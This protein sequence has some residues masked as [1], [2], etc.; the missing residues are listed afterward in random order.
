MED[1]MGNL[2][3]LIKAKLDEARLKYNYFLSNHHNQWLKGK[4]FKFIDENTIKLLNDNKEID[5]KPTD[6]EQD[7]KKL[8]TPADMF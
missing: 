8:Y 4:M 5:V 6:L 3:K 7:G 1:F 2:K